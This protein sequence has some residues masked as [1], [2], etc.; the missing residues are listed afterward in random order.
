MCSSDLFYLQFA[1]TRG[2]LEVVFSVAIIRA[3][4]IKHIV[5]TAT[6]FSFYIFRSSYFRNRVLATIF[7]VPSLYIIYIWKSANRS[8]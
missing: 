7:T 6:S 1:A 2:S 3:G 5:R 4:L 8:A